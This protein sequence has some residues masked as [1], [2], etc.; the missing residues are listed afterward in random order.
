[1]C[2]KPVDGL[3]MVHPGRCVPSAK[4]HFDGRRRLTARE[5]G[6]MAGC[7]PIAVVM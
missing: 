4:L 2:A 3:E 6:P 7:V 1:M 5:P